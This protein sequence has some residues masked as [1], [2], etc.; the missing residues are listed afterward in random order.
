MSSISTTTGGNI[1][2]LLLPDVTHFTI[3]LIPLENNTHERPLLKLHNQQPN[4]PVL[5]TVIQLKCMGVS[6][7]LSTSFRTLT[8]HLNNSLI[9]FYP[10]CSELLPEMNKRKLG[11]LHETQ[12][13]HT[14][15]H[16]R[17][18]KQVTHATLSQ[19]F[20]MRDG[21]I[22]QGAPIYANSLAKLCKQEDK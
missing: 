2:N 6:R 15:G 12:K 10:L 5:S 13:H 11:Q 19:N 14:S 17:Q 9:W 21:I 7:E 8:R 1:G 20:L 3:S 22:V 16:M 18:A 4:N